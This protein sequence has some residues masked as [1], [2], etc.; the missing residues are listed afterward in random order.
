[1][2]W[3]IKTECNILFE[4]DKNLAHVKLIF[5]I[6]IRN[7]HFVDTNKQF[8]AHSNLYSRFTFLQ[9]VYKEKQVQEEEAPIHRIRIT[10]TSRNVRSLEKV[11]ADL[12]KGSKTHKLAVKGPVRLPT[13]TLRITSRKTP[14][15]EGSKTWSRYEMRIH[16]RLIDLKSPSE[17]V[18]QIVSFSNYL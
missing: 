4:T 5:L 8:A 13:K 9:S 3:Y 2:W 15:G 14:C 12:I 6:N 16:K 10:L 11:C 17:I 18:K 1:M 7:V